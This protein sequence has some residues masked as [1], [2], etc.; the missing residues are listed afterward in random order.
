M[1]SKRKKAVRAWERNYDKNGLRLGDQEYLDEYSHM[2]YEKAK[3][4]HRRDFAISQVDTERYY[5][6]K[7]KEGGLVKKFFGTI[8]ILL[9]VLLAIGVGVGAS[10]GWFSG[11]NTCEIV[12]TTECECEDKCHDECECEE[13]EED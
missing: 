6:K 13:Q 7:E 9:I 11:S 10:T 1:P 5:R 2:P 12:C 3:I 4:K 8:A